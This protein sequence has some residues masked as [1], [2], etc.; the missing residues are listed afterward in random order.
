[1]IEKFE[2]YFFENTGKYTD[3]P[4][5][6]NIYHTMLFLDYSFHESKRDY[7]IPIYYHTNVIDN[8]VTTNYNFECDGAIIFRDMIETFERLF[9]D[10]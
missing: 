5:P 2:E 1:M 6:R 10:V 9:N 4:I 7:Y 8:D 3:N